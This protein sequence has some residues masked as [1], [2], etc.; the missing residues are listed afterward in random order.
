MAALGWSVYAFNNI[1]FNKKNLLLNV[2]LLIISFYFLFTVKLYI[3]MC[4][5]PALI[6]WWQITKFSKV[7]SLL[8]RVLI[9]P[10]VLVLSLGVA[11]WTVRKVG[12]GDSKYAVENLA[13]TAQVTAYDI[14]YWTGKDAGSTYS[15]G[16]LDGTF[17]SMIS[18]FPQAINVSLFRPYL[19][20]VR[21]P[22]MLLAAL[23]SLAI[24]LLTLV[25]LYRIKVIGVFQIGTNPLVFFLF[26]FC[27]YFC[28]CRWSI[29]FQFWHPY[30]I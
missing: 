9:A 8:G 13:Q 30:E 26:N 6:I 17:T 21:N 29:Y 22:L 24:L 28:V 16:E 18:L 7:R 4:L 23:E 12:E 15:L 27:D 11:Y 10:F 14:A 20:E 25:V 1:L 5:I 3:L 2:V 19:W